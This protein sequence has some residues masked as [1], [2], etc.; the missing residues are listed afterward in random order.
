MND[1]TH[2]ESSLAPPTP[3]RLL[4]VASTSTVK[5]TEHW[6]I[7]KDGDAVA[8]ELHLRHYSAYTYKDGREPKLFVGPGEKLVL[9]TEDAD[10]LFV[11]RKFIDDWLKE[12]SIWCAIF[13]NESMVLSSQLILEAERV[14]QC[15]WPN[16]PVYTH[17]RGESIK[18]ANPGYC[19]KMA[20]WQTCGRSKSGTTIL[21]NG[22]N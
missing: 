9:L 5:L 11:W 17:V 22:G 3:K 1:H 2:D 15:R 16:E 4:F 18:S 20:G 13:R 19:F 6:H 8:K 10:A 21:R 14:A 7:V 12:K